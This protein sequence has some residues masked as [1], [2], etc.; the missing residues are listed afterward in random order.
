MEP[1][2][3]SLA[4]ADCHSIEDFSLSAHGAKK[5]DVRTKPSGTEYPACFSRISDAAFPP[6]SDSSGVGDVVSDIVSS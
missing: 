2:D 6:T 5:A 3:S 1:G 4:A